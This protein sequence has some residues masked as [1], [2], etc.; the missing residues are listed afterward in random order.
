MKKDEKSKRPPFH[1]EFTKKVIERLKEGTTPWQK[2]WT[3]G[4]S[5]SVPHNPVSGTVYKG[6]NRLSLA[7]SGYDDPRWMTFKQANEQDLRIIAGSKSTTVVFYQWTKEQDKLDD[8]GKPILDENGKPEREQK[9][10]DRPILR[11]ANVFNAAQIEGMPPL[12]L[13]STTYEW[14]AEEKAETILTNSQAAIKYD[15]SDS[16]Y[17]RPLTDSIHLPP[18]VNFENAG[19]F[20]GTALHELGHWSGHSSRLNRD[21]SP[22]GTE[23]YAR[24]ELRAEIASWM[25]GEDLGIPHDPS[26]H[27]AYVASWV[28]ALEEDSYEIARA[29]RDA[30]HIK[31]YVLAFELERQIER[32]AER[33]QEPEQNITLSS[34]LPEKPAQEKTFL[35]VPYQEKEQAKKLGAKWDKEQKSWYAPEG[36]DIA[37][38]AKWLPDNKPTLAIVTHLS[39]EEE[40]AL[41]IRQAGLDLKG[42]PVMDGQIHRLP[43]QGKEANNLDG[44]YCGY[45]DGHPAGWVQNFSSSEKTKWIA[46][47]HALTDKEKERIAQEALERK[48]ARTRELTERQNDVAT[49]CREFYENSSP[50][51][52]DHPYLLRKGIDPYDIPNNLKVTPGG[53]H[54]VAPLIN[55]EGELRSLQYIHED[56][57]KRFQA[58]GQKQGCFCLIGATL[59]QDKDKKNLDQGEIILS[60]GVATGISLHAATQ[61]PVAVAFD[62]DNL[63][64]VAIALRQ[65]FPNAAITICA[66]NDHQ[67]KQNGKEWNKGV[68]RAQEAAQAVHGM[69]R[70]PTFTPEEKEQGLT[71][72]ND[73]HKSHGL[74]EVRKQ[75]GLIRQRQERE[76]TQERGLEL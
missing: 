58:H 3:A 25:L 66:D 23:N 31:D 11:Y 27:T 41:A 19:L 76:R 59:T 9:R 4:K 18:R 49:F 69:V 56:G 6:I 39:P 22:R 61:K 1:E 21:L 70:I 16:A 57:T 65:R 8:N 50:V 12:E 46:T 62:A 51:H 20:Y 17:Y 40:F 37:L 45:L 55:A 64:A 34:A 13:S 29:C 30:E 71:D 15:Q 60:E 35:S 67:H 24:E 32:E 28:K 74:A 36:T 33:M 48:E 47:G 44:A 72:F 2:P 5:P 38:M 10:L 52:S 53:Q 14:N 26:Q 75:L 63:K 68:E 73:L 42:A 7:L 43:L 54:I